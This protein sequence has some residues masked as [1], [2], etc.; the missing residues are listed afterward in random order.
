MMMIYLRRL[1]LLGGMSG[2]EEVGRQS[3]HLIGGNSRFLMKIMMTV[4]RFKMVMLIIIFI[5]VKIAI[6]HLGTRVRSASRVSD[7]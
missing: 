4:M 2:V 7:P 3:K 5:M 6:A 1:S